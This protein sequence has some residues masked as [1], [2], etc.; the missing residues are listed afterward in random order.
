MGQSPHCSKHHW[1]I[2]R[3][4]NPGDAGAIKGPMPSPFAIA[5][6]AFTTI[7]LGAH[8]ADE[9][10]TL[11]SRFPAGAL[12][13]SPAV[14][15]AI[16]TLGESGDPDTLPLLESLVNLEGTQ[17][18]GS[19]LRA[20]DTINQRTRQANRNA[21]RSPR[22]ADVSHWLSRHLPMGLNDEALGRHEGRA[23]AY[24]A[25]VF[26]ESVGTFLTEWETV[27]ARLEAQGRT[28][29]ALRVYAAAIVHGEFQAINAL[30]NFDLDTESLL[31][32]LLTALPAEHPTHPRLSGWLI[33]HGTAPTVRVF[34]DR[35]LRLS[36]LERA[37][38]LDALSQ[39]IRAGR[40]NSRTSSLAQRRIELSAADTHSAVSIFARTTL[41]E[42]EKP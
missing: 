26:G 4:Y 23:V 37:S 15:S 22:A 19:A 34:S 31:L 21:F 25:L 24:A 30:K 33:A 14:L 7:A 8:Q 6:Y 12:P 9:A 35:T 11:L 28:R 18:R 3:A 10:A 29:S 13:N 5:L 16:G 2:Y 40:L 27:S 39:M 38:S 32:G 42:L 1:G 20:I 17:V 36:A 41:I